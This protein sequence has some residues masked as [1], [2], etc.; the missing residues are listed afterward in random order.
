MIDWLIDQQWCHVGQYFLWL[1]FVLGVSVL[2]ILVL[3]LSLVDSIDFVVFCVSAFLGSYGSYYPLPFVYFANSY[4]L[5][6]ISL[7]PLSSWT[8]HCQIH[9]MRLHN[10]ED[11]WF[12]KIYPIWY[13]GK[14]QFVIIYDNMF[15]MSKVQHSHKS[16]TCP[17]FLFVLLTWNIQLDTDVLNN[18]FRFL[19]F[20]WLKNI[21]FP[22]LM[23]Y[24]FYII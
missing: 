7:M 20:N 9:Q 16:S 13:K 19:S 10:R 6:S 14:L 12:K 8:A 23:T 4:T 11:L 2:G 1:F 22:F 21:V 17:V 15:T 18:P 5:P 3:L 24:S